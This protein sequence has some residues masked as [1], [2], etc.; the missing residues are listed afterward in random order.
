MT[1]KEFFAALDRLLDHAGARRQESLSA[2][3]VEDFKEWD[4]FHTQI[5]S[6]LLGERLKQLQGRVAHTEKVAK[7]T[8]RA[9]GKRKAGGGRK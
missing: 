8:K 9:A 4:S 1:D 3:N 6:L 2:A 7:E 5:N